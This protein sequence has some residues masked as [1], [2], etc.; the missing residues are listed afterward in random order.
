MRLAIVF[1]C[2]Y[3]FSSLTSF[4]W[5]IENNSKNTVSSLHVVYPKTMRSGEDEILYPLV[6]LRTA[7]RRKFYITTL[8]YFDATEPRVKANSS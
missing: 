2:V 8:K 7:L 5:A 4:A 1:T 6:L 3:F